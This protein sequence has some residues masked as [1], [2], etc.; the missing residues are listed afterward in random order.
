MIRTAASSGITHFDTSPYYG[1]GL[2]ETDLGHFLHGQRAAFSVTTKVGLYP[3]GPASSHAVSVWGR[4]G[5]GKLVPAISLPLVSWHVDRARTSLQESMRRLKTDYVDFL[6]LHEPDIRLIRT[7][8]F[9]GW[10]EA[11]RARGS[12]R[13]W[14]LAGLA[15]QVA[16]WAQ[17]NHPLA[18]VVQTQDSIDQRQADF[19]FRCGRGLQFTYGYLSSWKKAGRAERPE[20]VIRQALERNPNGAVIVST[21]HS[22]F[23][24]Q[25]AQTAS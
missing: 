15:S 16:P 19:L 7:D 12:V 10:M 8:E 22:E 2:A 9:V 6:F 18:Q 3:C 11:E 20:S 21:L 23:I 13:A 4:K 24:T 5:L 25:L 14:G 17:E 1:Y